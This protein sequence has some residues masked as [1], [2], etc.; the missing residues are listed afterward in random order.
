MSRCQA[1]KNTSDAVLA[2]VLLVE[3]LAR[4]DLRSDSMM[5]RPTSVAALL[6]MSLTLGCVS[7]PRDA[8]RVPATTANT[9]GSAA[10]SPPSALVKS[11][12][13]SRVLSVAHTTEVPVEKNAPPAQGH[14]M[15]SVVVTQCNLIVAVYL[16]MPDGRLLRFDKSADI[17]AEQLLTMAYTATRSERVEVSCEDAGAVGFEQHNPL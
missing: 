5:Y 7:T 6:A 3:Y 4:G 11:P 1:V 12:G 15:T 8:A 2:F 14:P 13:A 10:T 16:T 9:T 17:P